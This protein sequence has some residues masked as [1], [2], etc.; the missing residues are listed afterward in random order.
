[1]VAPKSRNSLVDATNKYNSFLSISFLQIY[2]EPPKSSPAAGD[3]VAHQMSNQYTGGLNFLLL[4]FPHT[5]FSTFPFPRHC[6][7]KSAV[8]KFLARRKAISRVFPPIARS[9]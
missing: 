2:V 6:S 5:A 1:M 9:F 8:K 3:A 4:P 7:S